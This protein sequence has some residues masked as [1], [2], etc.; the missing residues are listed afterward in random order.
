G[1][2]CG[3]KISF[4]TERMARTPSEAGIQTLVVR[5]A[6]GGISLYMSSREVMGLSTPSDRP[7]YS[8]GIKISFG[9]ERMARTPSEAGIQTLVVRSALGGT[10]SYMFSQQGMESCMAL[11]SKIWEA[12]CFGIVICLGM[13]Q[14]VQMPVKAGTLVR[15]V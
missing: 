12:A 9:T 14:T 8:C 7:G 5:S 6:L 15:E 10:R 13:A 1:N 11:E 2:S 3:I 4:G